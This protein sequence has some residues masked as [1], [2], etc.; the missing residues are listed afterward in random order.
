MVLCESRVRE[1]WLGDILEDQEIGACAE[2]GSTERSAIEYSHENP[3]S[4]IASL[5]RSS[6]PTFKS[7]QAQ[8]FYLDSAINGTSYS[9]YLN[10]DGSAPNELGDFADPE[11]W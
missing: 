4:V 6:S 9:F 7:I 11:Q 8:V 2:D 10:P 5:L 1:P 3:F